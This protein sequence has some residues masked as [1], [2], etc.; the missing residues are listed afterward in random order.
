MTNENWS[1][2]GELNLMLKYN[3]TAHELL[4][5]K[6]I[7]LAKENH[8][9]ELVRYFTNVKDI[10]LKDTLQSLQNKSVILK[11]YKIPNKGESFIPE[12]VEFNSQF[13]N[14]YLQNSN[15]LGMELFMNYPSFTVI[16]GK[17]Y[18]LRNVTK[19]YKSIDD[20]CFAYGKAIRFNPEQHQKIMEL[21]QFAKDNNLIRSGICDFIESRQW[22]TIEDIKNGGSVVFDAMEGL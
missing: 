7:F 16:N 12:D 3:L 5:V 20:M 18:S 22:L 9:N 17:Q 4:T 19:L 21:L 1:L 13:I 14:S 6:L 10:P 2:Y 15:D 8:K 11:S